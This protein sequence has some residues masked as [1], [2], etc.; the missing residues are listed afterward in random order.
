MV[1]P[2]SRGIPRAPRY[3][4][5]WPAG[6][7]AVRLRGCHP[8]RPPVPGRSAPT[9]TR[10]GRGSGPRHGPQPH[11]RNGCRLGT[12]VVWATAPFAH[13]Y[14]G[15]RVLLPLPRGTEMFQFPRFPSAAYRFGGGCPGITRGGL[16]HSDTRGSTPVDGSPRLFAVPRVLR[17]PSAPRH[18]PRALHRSTPPRGDPEPPRS[19]SLDT[20]LFTSSR[21]ATGDEKIPLLSLGELLITRRPRRLSSSRTKPDRRCLRTVGRISATVPTAL[22][23]VARSARQNQ[24]AS[25]GGPSWIRTRDL[26]LIRTA[27]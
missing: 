22:H 3:S 14:W 4:G 11:R 21:T 27:L 26:G 10:P 13:H 16:P 12:A 2:A 1:P 7:R 19:N 24:V 25:A 9:L 20:P 8:L 23:I 18:P 6:R 17:R 15:P 5:P